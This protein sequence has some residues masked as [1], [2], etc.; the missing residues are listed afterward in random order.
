MAR[1]LHRVEFYGA[2]VTKTRFYGCLLDLTAVFEAKNFS[3]A[4]YDGCVVLLNN[5]TSAFTVTNM[6]GGDW[7]Q[8]QI[9]S[10]DIDQKTVSRSLHRILNIDDLY[11]IYS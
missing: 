8:L 3:L 5:A 11:R 9:D 4:K 2:D 10:D 6:A 7:V 1:Y